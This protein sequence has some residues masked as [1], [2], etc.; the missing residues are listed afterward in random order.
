MRWVAATVVLLALSPAGAAQ[1]PKATL[2]TFAGEWTGHTE[3]SWLRARAA[4]SRSSTTAAARASSRSR[5]SSRSRPEPR[6]MQPS[7]P[8]L[9][10][11][12]LYNMRTYWQKGPRPRI[13]QVA[14][15]ACGTACWPRRSAARST[16]TSAPRRAARGFAGREQGQ[17]RSGLAWAR[18]GRTT[19]CA[20]RRAAGGTRG[21][22]CD[23]RK[24]A[25]STSSPSGSSSSR[26]T[27]SGN[28]GCGRP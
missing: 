17:A 15:L 23:S 19:G 28:R 21:S 16:A 9:T 25:S 27:P 6:R 2:A 22:W 13:G 3:A 8:V 24:A 20:A 10:A 11:A 5:S 4:R 12:K 7:R 18:P 1:P 14:T 26:R